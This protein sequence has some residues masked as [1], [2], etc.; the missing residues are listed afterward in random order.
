MDFGSSSFYPFP[1]CPISFFVRSNLVDF[2]RFAY[3]ITIRDL[4]ASA[5]CTSLRALLD[6]NIPLRLRLPRNNNNHR[7]L[8]TTLRLEI[9]LHV[10]VVYGEKL[11]LF[12]PPRHEPGLSASLRGLEAVDV[13]LPVVLISS[14]LVMLCFDL[15]W[16]Q[17][18]ESRCA[19][20]DL[21]V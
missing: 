10:A 1:C 6:H 16:I 15:G 21:L 7:S 19:D 3:T 4:L 9:L 17:V 13:Q 8:A 5:S 14:W 18:L 12:F 11:L 20:S 2:E